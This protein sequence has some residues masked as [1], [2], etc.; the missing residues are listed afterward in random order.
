MYNCENCGAALRY[1]ISSGLLKCDK[2]MS[3]FAPDEY[4]EK[5]NKDSMSGAEKNEDYDGVYDTI[6]YRCPHCGGE[7]YTEDENTAASFCSYCGASAVMEEE[8]VGIKRPKYVIPFKIDK[9]MCKKLYLKQ[10]RSNIF[11]DSKLKKPGH[12]E[13]FRGI[14]IPY[15]VYSAKH[16]GI[17]S[18]GADGKSTRKGDYIYTPKYMVNVD[19]DDESTGVSY[20]ASASFDDVLSESIAPYDYNGVKKFYPSYLTGFF[21]D[22]AD[23][24]G[25]VYVD[26]AG[27]K[28]DEITLKRIENEGSLKGLTVENEKAISSFSKIRF[29]KRA[30]SALYPV[31]FLTYR[32]E[33]RLAYSIINGQTGKAY[34]DVPIDRRKYFLFSFILAI[35]IFLFLESL[36]TYTPHKVLFC[37]MIIAAI[38]A[39]MC[40]IELKRLIKRNNHEDDKGYRS[41]Q[42]EEKKKEF[43]EMDVIDLTDKIK[44]PEKDKKS[45]LA[46]IALICIIASPFLSTLFIYFSQ[47]KLLGLVFGIGVGI[48]LFFSILDKEKKLDDKK[49][50]KEFIVFEVAIWFSTLVYVID[51][52]RD[53]ISYGAII[54]LIIGI[55]ILISGIIRLYN[56][57]ATKPLPHFNRRGGSQ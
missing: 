39:I 6:R 21:A 54:L 23:V 17:A 43:N 38:V 11:A 51:P 18:F 24:D 52:V 20:D 46:T 7:I 57:L 45:T 16:T 35:P 29:M 28:F 22:T 1:D 5:H 33:D 10:V 3:L 2:C 48:G 30:D 12:I 41:K 32:N 9:D 47:F 42:L 44:I 36:I 15:W 50:I 37:C 53:F 49:I 26:E 55:I 27:E 25:S 4:D 8:F 13:K 40:N 31:W 34:A 14:Y 19:I 56:I